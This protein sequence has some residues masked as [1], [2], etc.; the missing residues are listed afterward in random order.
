MDGIDT[1]NIKVCI[2]RRRDWYR[3]PLSRPMLKMMPKQDTYVK[4]IILVSKSSENRNPA[5]WPDANKIGCQRGLRGVKKVPAAG[6]FYF[7]RMGVTQ[8][9][10]L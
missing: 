2:Q 3:Q 4:V 9:A 10:F 1:K 7:V 6:T 5:S 8:F